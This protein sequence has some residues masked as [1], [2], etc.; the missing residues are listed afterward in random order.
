MGLRP[1][2]AQE[3][4]QCAVQS[5]PATPA[6][7]PASGSRPCT[8]WHWRRTAADWRQRARTA[9]V[10]L[11]QIGAAPADGLTLSGHTGAVNTLAF[12]P[13]GR[14]LASAGND[15]SVRIWNSEDGEQLAV[16]TADES[17]GA[18]N[19]INLV[20]YSPDGKWLASG[21]SD[22][23]VRLWRVPDCRRARPGSSRRNG[24]IHSL[25]R[26]Q[27]CRLRPEFLA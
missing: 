4:R 8:H 1:P 3:Q 26:S 25:A 15:G 10:G 13:D 22:G 6:R 24:D 23:G 17:S 18:G 5:S 27:R 14:Q 12:S 11:W 9:R 16:L 20:V 7:F 19:F 2:P 21:S